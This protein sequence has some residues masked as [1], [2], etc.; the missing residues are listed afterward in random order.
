MP[1]LFTRSISMLPGSKAQQLSNMHYR[2]VKNQNR[3]KNNGL[4]WIALMLL[5]VFFGCL[6]VASAGVPEMWTPSKVFFVAGVLLFM[7][8]NREKGKNSTSSKGNPS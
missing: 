5:V 2:I 1:N 3:Q 6:G 4:E 8:G 7:L